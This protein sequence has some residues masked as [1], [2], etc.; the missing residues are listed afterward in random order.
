MKINFNILNNQT[1]LAKDTKPGHVYRDQYHY[2]YIRFLHC[3]V[4]NLALKK[5]K[6]EDYVQ[7]LSLGRGGSFQDTLFGAVKLPTEQFT[8]V[9]EL[10]MSLA[11]SD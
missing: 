9:G 8:Y 11:D 1:V 10:V 6:H 4:V 2:Y 7:F 5:E 3:D